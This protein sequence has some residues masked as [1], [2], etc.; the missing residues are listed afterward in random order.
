MGTTPTEL[1]TH[2]YRELAEMTEGYSGSDLSVLVRDALMAPVR[3]LMEATHFKPVSKVKDGQ[4]VSK[5][6]PCSPGDRGAVE[7][8][9]T[10]V[11]SE[12]LEEPTLVKSDF[13][14][15]IHSVKASVNKDD[16][17]KQI[18]WANDAGVLRRFRAI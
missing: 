13:I 10:D 1:S 15:A 17:L 18:Q 16:V 2:D 5:W 7:R 4:K 11:A 9:W 14:K 8:T 6:Q 3:K 12:E